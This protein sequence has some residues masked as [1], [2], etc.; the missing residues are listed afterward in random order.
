MPH[1]IIDCPDDL[2][3]HHDGQQVMQI[4]FDAAEESALFSVEDIKVRIR[5]FADFVTGGS[6]GAF[7][8]VFAYIMEGRTVSQKNALSKSIVSR[9]KTRLPDVPV[10]SMSVMDFEQATY[11]NRNTV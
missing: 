7:L 2:L 3:S 9:L 6:G 4:V 10:V 5:P 8:H 1:F 11:N